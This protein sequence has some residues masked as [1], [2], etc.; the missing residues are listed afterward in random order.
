MGSQTYGLPNICVLTDPSQSWWPRPL[1]RTSGYLT[2]VLVR[3]DKSMQYSKLQKLTLEHVA[4]LIAD[5]PAKTVTPAAL[6]APEL[7]LEMPF[8]HRIDIWSFGCLA[9]AFITTASLFDI[10]DYSFIPKEQTDDDH[11]LQMVDVLGQIP[12]HMIKK[13][14]RH[15]RY[16]GPNLEVIRTDVGPSE[17]C[18][19]PIYVGPTMEDKFEENRPKCIDSEEASKVLSLLRRI[20][21]YEPDQRPSTAEILEDE[22]IKSIP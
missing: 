10:A 8:D 11:L 6:R 13:W 22:W 21:Q 9:F 1:P 18:E 14:E 4:F 5:P 17:A 16:F 12:P 20:L 7:V 19:Y 15:S 2:L 3:Y